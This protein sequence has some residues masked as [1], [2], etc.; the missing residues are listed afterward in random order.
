MWAACPGEH[1]SE[2]SFHEKRGTATAD[3]R[4]IGKI[5]VRRGSR[6]EFPLKLLLIDVAS[7]FNQQHPCA[8]FRRA[9]DFDKKVRRVREFMHHRK[10]EREINLA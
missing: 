2:L 4:T 3:G 1:Y 6:G 7:W 5:E 9:A 8:C 10:G